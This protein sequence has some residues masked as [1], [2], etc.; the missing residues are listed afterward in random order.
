LLKD[1]AYRE[2]LLQR[3]EDPVVIEYF[4]YRFD[5]WDKRSASQMVENTLN[6]FSNLLFSDVLHYSLGQEQNRLNFDTILRDGTSVI[7]NLGGLRREIKKLLGCLITIGMENAMYARDAI[8]PWERRNYFL[9]IDEFKQFINIAEDAVDTFL[10][11]ARK[12]K[13]WLVLA[14]QYLGELT[15]ELVAALQNTQRIVLKLEDD[16]ISMAQRVGKY[17]PDLYKHEFEDEE[18]RRRANPLPYNVQEEYELLSQRHQ[19]SFSWRRLYPLQAQAGEVQSSLHPG[20]N[21]RHCKT[22]AR[23]AVVRRSIN[24]ST[25]CCGADGQCPLFPAA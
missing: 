2:E 6:K 5:D 23:E 8:P 17:K 21:E 10:S 1:K 12:F 19:G 9:M 25:Q 13:T 18:A 3:V 24:D 16:A 14:H 11:E 22:R 7:I 20:E 15:P 4:H